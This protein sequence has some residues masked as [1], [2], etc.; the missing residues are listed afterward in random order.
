MKVYVINKHLKPLMP[1]SPRKARLLLKEGKARISSRDP[2][3]IQL[4]YGSSGYTQPGNLGIDAGYQN[5]GYSVVNEKEE[6]IGGEVKMLPSKPTAY[7]R[8]NMES[9]SPQNS[10]YT[11]TLW[12]DVG[13]L[14]ALAK[15][16]FSQNN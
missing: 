10:S 12:S 11:A 8:A 4:I 16:S 14:L 9:S 6:L 5:I 15:S 2:F 3:T 1:T 13:L 7:L